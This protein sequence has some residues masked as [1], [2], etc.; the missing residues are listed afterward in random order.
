MGWQHS[1]FKFDHS[2][3]DEFGNRKRAREMMAG[4]SLV[5]APVLFKPQTLKVLMAAELEDKDGKSVNQVT[6]RCSSRV[7]APRCATL[8]LDCCCA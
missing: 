7:V 6:T 3:R 4:D 8:Q 5:P 1:L 2:V